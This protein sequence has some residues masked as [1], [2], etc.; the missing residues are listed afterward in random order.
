MLQIQ[1]ST[2]RV[3]GIL[4]VLAAIVFQISGSSSF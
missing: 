2:N 4:L 3:F 1:K